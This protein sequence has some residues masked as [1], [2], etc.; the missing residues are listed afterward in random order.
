[1]ISHRETQMSTRSKPRTTKRPPTAQELSAR[2]ENLATSPTE[3]PRTRRNALPFVSHD[4]DPDY[5]D[6][7]TTRVAT[8]PRGTRS[9]TRH[10]NL[11]LERTPRNDDDHDNH[12]EDDHDGHDDNI[13]LTTS[14][15]GRRASLPDTTS[16]PKRVT[17]KK[18]FFGTLRFFKNRRAR[19]RRR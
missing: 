8:T 1:M 9:A 14:R 18:R 3:A 17:T 13:P 15:R 7:A 16:T 19:L 5:R 6:D 11:S 2:L 4:I 10:E 12:E